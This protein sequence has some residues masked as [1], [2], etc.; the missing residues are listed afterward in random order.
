MPLPSFS[1]RMFVLGLRGFICNVATSLVSDFVDVF[2]NEIL[3]FLLLAFL[4]GSQD[5]QIP[6]PD[7]PCLTAGRAGSSQ[8]NVLRARSVAGFSTPG[9]NPLY[10]R[11]TQGGTASNLTDFSCP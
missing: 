10:T 1:I 4:S 11:T 2:S 8:Q 7:H 5:E 6:V 3:R 9:T